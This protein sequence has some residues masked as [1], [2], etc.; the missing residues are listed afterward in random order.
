MFFDGIA[1]TGRL[2][3]AA[4]IAYFALVAML[5]ASGKRALSRLNAFDLVV[6]VALGPTLSTVILD[7]EVPLLDGVAALAAPVAG[8]NGAVKSHAPGPPHL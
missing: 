3:L 1:S 8:Q 6:T 5:R 2:L 7:R 4:V